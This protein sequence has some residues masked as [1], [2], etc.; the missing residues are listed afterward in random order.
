MKYLTSVETLSVIAEACDMS[1]YE[2]AHM[3]MLQR[4]AIIRPELY[5]GALL[6]VR[7]AYRI[8]ENLNIRRIEITDEGEIWFY[9]DG[10]CIESVQSENFTKPYTELIKSWLQYNCSYNAIS[11]YVKNLH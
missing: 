8:N 2:V 4:F 11:S 1:T 5:G 7:N 10:R 9:D 6:I 3:F